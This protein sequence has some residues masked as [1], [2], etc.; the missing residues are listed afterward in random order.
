MDNYNELGRILQN[1]VSPVVLISGIGMILLSLTNRYGRVIDRTRI[2]KK[3]VIKASASEKET[4]VRE[5]NILYRRSRI[6]LLSVSLSVISI[7][8]V[9]LLMIIIFIN[10][11][12]RVNLFTLGIS[13]FTISLITLIASILLFIKDMTLSL[14]ALTLDIEYHIED[15]KKD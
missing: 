5:I 1:V 2:L 9:C 3:E 15:R 13:V 11:L 8:F 12:F 10:H 4:I 7:L 6:L 14:K